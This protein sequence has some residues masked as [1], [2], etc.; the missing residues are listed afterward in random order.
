MKYADEFIALSEEKAFDLNRR[1]VVDTQTKIYKQ[2]LENGLSKFKNLESSK[3]KAHILKWWTIENLDKLLPQFETNFQKRGGKVIWANDA[4]EAQQE[5]LH[6][7]QNSGSQLVAKTKSSACEEI[8]LTKLLA[9]KQIESFDSDLGGFILHELGK[10]RNHPVTDTTEIPASDI[11]QV[12]QKKL[13]C[14]TDESPTQLT[15]K[16]RDFIRE[17]QIKADVCIS[18]A[19]FLVAETGSISI[20]ENEGN[21]RVASSFAKIHIV[22]AGI[23]KLV[24]GLSDLDL[25]WPLLATHSTGQNLAVY[26]TL[27]SGPRR[28][29]ETDGPEEMYVILLD[30]GRSQLLAQREQRQALNCIQCGA[31]HNLSPVHQNIGN[32]P[33]HSV[34]TGP[35]GA[36]VTPHTRGMKDFNHLSEASSLCG[37]YTEFCPVNINLHQMM[38]LNR[39]DAASQNLNSSSENLNWKLWKKSMMSRKWLDFWGAKMKNVLLKRVFKKSWTKYKELPKVAPKSFAQYWEEK[40]KNIDIDTK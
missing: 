13:A 16:A 31:C 36:I 15:Q 38:L 22:V 30:N 6:I 1:S 33:Y 5:I 14:N 21:I 25:L 11:Y 35:I 26:N 17:K 19:N 4:H 29:G 37:K 20:C 24:A 10:N 18:G 34:Y 3:R 27:F 32:E 28:A 9:D 8:G 2:R 12:L 39:R 23:D 40:R 7:I